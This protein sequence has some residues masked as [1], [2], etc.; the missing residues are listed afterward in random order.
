MINI[1]TIHKQQTDQDN[2]VCTIFLPGNW[3]L[4]YIVNG[5]T[6]IGGKKR[7][8]SCGIGNTRP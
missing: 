8:Q 5:E 3:L 7:N 6:V 4:F 1:E 2:M